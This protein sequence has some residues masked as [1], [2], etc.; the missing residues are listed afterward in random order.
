MPGS[1]AAGPCGRIAGGVESSQTATVLTLSAAVRIAG[2]AD[3]SFLQSQPAGSVTGAAL[4]GTPAMRAFSISFL[5]LG[6]PVYLRGIYP[7]Q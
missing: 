6:L 3:F 5:H 4:S 1:F 7:W 2:S